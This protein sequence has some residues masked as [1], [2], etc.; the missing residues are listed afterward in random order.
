MVLRMRSPERGILSFT[1]MAAC[2]PRWSPPVLLLLARAEALAA[3]DTHRSSNSCLLF[4][5]YHVP[6]Q[7]Y[8]RFV[9]C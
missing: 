2:L 4:Y 3:G 6:G 1:W 9:D 7:R 5:T 8:V